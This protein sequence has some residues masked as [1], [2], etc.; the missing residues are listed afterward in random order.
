MLM[1]AFFIHKRIKAKRDLKNHKIYLEC[2]KAREN[3]PLIIKLHKQL[4]DSRRFGV[5]LKKCGEWATICSDIVIRN[6]NDLPQEDV[7]FFFLYE[8]LGAFLPI[9]IKP[10]INIT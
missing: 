9:S 3:N 4:E 1:V 10:F 2:M 7:D 6:M 8:G 5:E